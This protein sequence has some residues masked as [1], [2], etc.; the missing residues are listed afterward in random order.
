MDKK[1]KDIEKEKQSL[2]FLKQLG[3]LESLNDVEKMIKDNK[4]VFKINDIKYRVRQP[5]FEENNELEKFRRKI[6]LEYINDDTMMFRKQWI[7][8]YKTKGIDID[9]MEDKI[10]K[11]INKENQIMVKL[12]QTSD[13]KRVDDLK[14]Q[15]IELRKESAFINIEKT[16]LLSFSIEDQMMVAVNSYYTY[17]VLEKLENEKDPYDKHEW[18][19]VYKTYEDFSKSTDTK[20]TNKA[21]YYSNNL[22][23]SNGV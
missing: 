5:N 4:I 13:E 23:Y 1:K 8:K 3:D 17:L 10:R 9:E 12:A 7:E 22:I 14:S 18:V 16:D 21:L 19:R 20:L 2:E 15:I 6:Y 11:N